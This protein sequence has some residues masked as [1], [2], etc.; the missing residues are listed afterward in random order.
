[1]Y[2]T[3]HAFTQR[4]APFSQSTASD[5][6]TRPHIARQMLA[7]HLNQDTELASRPIAQI[8]SIVDWLDS[9]VGLKE[10][11]LCDLGCG[12]GLYAER[13]ADRG[14][15][16]TG[17]DF[18]SHSLDYAKKQAANTGRDIRYVHAD[19]LRDPLPA[20]FD[21]VTL[22]YHDYCALSP[23]QRAQLLTRIHAMLVPGGSFVLDVSGT[24]SISAMREQTTVEQDLMGGF[25]SESDYIGMHR[26]LL[27]PDDAVSLDHFLIIEPAE[28]WQ[29]YNWLQ[30]FTPER[31]T[32]ELEEAGFT[33]DIL[34]GSLEGDPVLEDGAA[35]AVIAHR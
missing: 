1:M 30:H 20:D 25:W 19:Y 8:E 24:G 14:A 29:I 16:V 27:Y 28:T 11:R 2:T 18:S 5:L 15:R 33:V 17:V 12:P 22:I 21:L 31:L 3:L 34:T 6:W 10:K 23:E 35:L 13:F 4:P 9:A 32:H 7:Y 26:T